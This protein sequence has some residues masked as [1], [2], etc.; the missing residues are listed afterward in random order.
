MHLFFVSVKKERAYYLHKCST[1]LFNFWLT[2]NHPSKTEQQRDEKVSIFC[3]LRSLQRKTFVCICGVAGGENGKKVQGL[4]IEL[5]QLIYIQYYQVYQ[6]F[7]HQLLNKQKNLRPLENQV[8]LFKIRLS[9]VRLSN[10][11]ISK[12]TLLLTL[13]Y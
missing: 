11:S 5:V 3:H 4:F 12:A 8:N 13:V 2:V 6:Y 9:D 10:I 1:F 7:S